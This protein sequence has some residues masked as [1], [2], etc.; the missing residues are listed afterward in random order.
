[1]APAGTTPPPAT[2]APQGE[3]LSPV[4]IGGIGAGVAAA[5]AVA[6]GIARAAGGVESAKAAAASAV[7]SAKRMEKE[8]VEE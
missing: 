1:A 8:N 7:E 4:E 2:S 5:G 6:T 3:G